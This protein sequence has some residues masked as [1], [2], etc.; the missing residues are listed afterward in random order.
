MGPV[1]HIKNSSKHF[2]YLGFLTLLGPVLIK[3]STV[4][5]NLNNTRPFLILT[6]A[7]AMTYVIYYVAGENFFF[8]VQFISKKNKNIPPKNT[9]PQRFSF[10]LKGGEACQVGI[11]RHSMSDDW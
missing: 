9:I 11:D 8:S 10:D 6:K 7:S 5:A 3:I 2:S 1:I 4:L